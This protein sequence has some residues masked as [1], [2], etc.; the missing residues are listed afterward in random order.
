M[1]S[2]VMLVEVRPERRRW[3]S[4]SFV[5][6]SHLVFITRAE[7][8]KDLRILSQVVLFL[9]RL[10]HFFIWQALGGFSTPVEMNAERRG[11]QSAFDWDLDQTDERRVERFSNDRPNTAL[12]AKRLMELWH[13]THETEEYNR[14]GFLYNERARKEQEDKIEPVLIDLSY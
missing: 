14:F 7:K 8:S 13:D 5:A 4:F 2:Y 3:V 11:L 12:Y 1:E 9:M 10:T 6:P